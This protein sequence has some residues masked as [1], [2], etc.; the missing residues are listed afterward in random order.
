MSPTLATPEH[1]ELYRQYYAAR[2]LSPRSPSRWLKHVEDLCLRVGAKTLLDYGCG[3]ARGLSLSQKVRVTDYDP[4]VPGFDARPVGCD[5]VASIHT[6]EHVEP[7]KIGAVIEDIESLAR[8]AVI[9][10]ISVQPSSKVLP[11]GSPWHCLV[12]PVPW[13]M[14]VLRKYTPHGAQD[15]KREYAAVWVRR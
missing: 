1:L 2:D 6:L 8:L 4:G 14:D 5:V 11:D 7:D 13:W 15:P 10:V 3:T 9:L 12:R